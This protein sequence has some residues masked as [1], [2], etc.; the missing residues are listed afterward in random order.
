MLATEIE[1]FLCFGDAADERADDRFTSHDQRSSIKHRIQVAQISYQ[2]QCA[3]YRQCRQI[4]I[5][6]VDIRYGVDN[7][8]E[9]TLYLCYLSFI[10]GQYNVVRA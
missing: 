3:I 8:V 2:Y 7:Q 10:G 4:G 5:D 1:H 9:T 6:V